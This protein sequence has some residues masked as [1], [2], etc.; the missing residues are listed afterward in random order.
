MSNKGETYEHGFKTPKGYFEDFEARIFDES[1]ISKLPDASG[2]KV[3]E[4]YFESFEAP[5]LLMAASAKETP[6]VIQLL[7]NKYVRYTAAI[8][9]SVI[10]ILSIVNNNAS[11]VGTIDDI[12]LTAISEYIEDENVDFDTFDVIALLQE[13]ELTNLNTQNQYITDE[14]LEAY[15]LETLDDATLLTE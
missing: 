2:F 12:E 8:A 3:P 10:L 13:D 14:I 11:V 4:G 5:E 7:R 1:A 9:A 6:K 15:L